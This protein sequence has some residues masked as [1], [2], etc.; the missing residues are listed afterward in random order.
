LED[1]SIQDGQGLGCEQVNDDKY[2]GSIVLIERGQCDFTDKVLNAQ[3]R[4]ASAVVVINNVNSNPF[5][6]AGDNPNINIPA[7]MV[8]TS[9]GNSI[10]QIMNSTLASLAFDASKK[11]MISSFTGIPAQC[12]RVQSPPFLLRPD[13]TISMWVNFGIRGII[14]GG[15]LYDRANVGLFNGKDRVTIKP[16]GGEKYNS[17]LEVPSL[18]SCP[19]PGDI[20]WRES[21]GATFKEV[22]FSANSLLD[23]G[24]AGMVQLDIALATGMMSYGSFISVQRVELQNV[25]IM[26]EDKGSSMCPSAAPSITPSQEPSIHHSQAPSIEKSLEPSTTPSWEPTLQPSSSSPIDIL[27]SGDLSESPV[28]SDGSPMQI[29]NKLMFFLV[30]GVGVVFSLI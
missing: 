4:G 20:G 29:L 1:V 21:N 3:L 7:V 22:V 14:T 8:S 5:N 19:A 11:E 10:K 9:D 26:V 12:N 13:T 27:R 25:G 30:A 23:T 28:T 18:S 2:T 17:K 16:D 15:Q 6:M 24:M